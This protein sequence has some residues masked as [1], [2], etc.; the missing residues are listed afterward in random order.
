MRNVDTPVSND[1]T[2]WG[3]NS[4]DYAH[5]PGRWEQWEQDDALARAW[6]EALHASGI[7][8]KAAVERAAQRW[9]SGIRDHLRNETGLRLST[10]D[11]TQS[12]P[13]RVVDANTAASPR[14]AREVQRVGSSA[15]EP[16]IDC[17][18]A[19]GAVFLTE[20]YGRIVE[21]L[22]VKPAA[23]LQELRRVCQFS[24]QIQTALASAE[25]REKWVTI[26]QDVLG[27]YFFRVPIVHLYWMPIGIASA[28]VGC[29]VESVAVIV[30]TH[31][32]AHV[33][34]H[35]GADIDGFR[36]HTD[37]FAKTDWGLSRAWQ[38]S[39][40][41]WSLGG[42]NPEL[43]GCAEPTTS[44]RSYP[45]GPTRRTTSGGRRVTLIPVNSFDAP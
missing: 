6:G 21:V 42:W 44:F 31:E 13:V 28:L 2:A 3:D 45:S 30:L 37:A 43:K 29:D 1:E 32:L 36:W 4:R 16:V 24:V 33:Y 9:N 15:F 25:L 14:C 23:E 34:T 39:I 8:A 12:V 22:Q 10:A 18:A 17:Q 38:N 5:K 40:R 7:D 11:S 41:E 19:R 35:L 20:H 27:V 26:G